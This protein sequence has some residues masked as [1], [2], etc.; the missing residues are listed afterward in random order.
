MKKSKD[1]PKL[2]SPSP[3]VYLLYFIFLLFLIFL[4][5]YL[6]ERN[7]EDAL[8]F[9][10]TAA[11]AFLIGIPFCVLVHEAGHL[12]F[13]LATGYRM[14]SFRLF[15]LILKQK[16]GKWRICREPS[17]ISGMAGQCLMAPPRKKS[18]KF[19]YRLYNAGGVLLGFAV[20]AVFITV[21][22]AVRLPYYFGFFLFTTGLY[23][24]VLN[25]FN[26]IPTS[27]ART[28][29]DGTNGRAAK[30]SQTAR[31]AFWNQLEYAALQA[32]GV[33]T[34][35]MPA[36]LF[37]LPEKWALTNALAVTE[38]MML[39]D[40]EEDTGAYEE[41][42]RTA[43]HILQ[44]ARPIH[45][46]YR[47]SLT[48]ELLFFELILRCDPD[49]IHRLYSETEKNLPLLKNHASTYRI[50][51]AYHLLWSKQERAAKDAL[52]RFESLAERN[53]TGTL[54]DRD[55]IVYTQKL[56]EARKKEESC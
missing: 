34:R 53:P 49:E 28:V 44:N 30:R 3:A 43:E 20:S 21:S 50:L 40:R 51:Y 8:L 13:G 2:C 4:C 32:Q 12:L 26:A 14:I 36:E 56:Y 7:A 5:V 27:G 24:A 19:P 11:A 39:L 48:A 47:A 46:L 31:D 35:D 9:S 52:A 37:F 22:L 17:P 55:S 1:S 10:L 15:F 33:R 29:N 45:P 54:P 16:N 38:G 41:A 6:P 18:G 25:L 23:G 42:R